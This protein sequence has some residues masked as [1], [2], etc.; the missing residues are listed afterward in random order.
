MDDPIDYRF[1]VLTPGLYLWVRN[2]DDWDVVCL[3]AN[4]RQNSIL[5]NAR[6]IADMRHVV[7]SFADFNHSLIE[8]IDRKSTPRIEIFLAKPP[9]IGLWWCWRVVHR[10]TLPQE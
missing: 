2:V 4:I 6:Q 7:E 8:Q 10:A 5:K 1:P 3:D 9:R